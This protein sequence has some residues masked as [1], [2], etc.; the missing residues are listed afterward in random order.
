MEK[1]P[2]VIRPEKV[3]AVEEI[4][5]QLS[6][7]SMAVLTDYRGLTVAQIAD[8]RRQLRASNVELHVVKNTLARLAAQKTGKEALLPSLVGPTALAVGTGDPSAMS[9]VLTDVIRTQ[10]LPMTIRGALLGDRMLGTAEV[11]TLATLPSRE[12]LIAQVVGTIQAPIAGLVG[13]L[14]GTLQTLVG[15]LDARRQQLE[16]QGAA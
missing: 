4:A 2:T 6:R 3:A 1:R 16:E 12:E 8:L 10:R 15:V 5:E 7:A 14:S 11:T 9:K 13:V